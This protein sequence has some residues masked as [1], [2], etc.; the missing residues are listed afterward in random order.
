MIS[1]CDIEGKS[2]I[3]E[4]TIFSFD[5]SS[6]ISTVYVQLILKFT[7]FV[8]RN[9]LNKFRQIINMWFSPFYRKHFKFSDYVSEEW[10]L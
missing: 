7:E 9:I 6:N 1:R 2:K 4:T 5:V 10:S 3:D 8:E